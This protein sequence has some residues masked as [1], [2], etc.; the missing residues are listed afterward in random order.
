MFK[1]SCNCFTDRSKTALHLWILSAVL[2]VSCLF[3]YSVLSVPCS[4]VIT[5]WEKLTCVMFSFLVTFP[6]GVPGKVWY[7]V[8]SIPNLRLLPYFNSGCIIIP[9]K[10]SFLFMGHRQMMQT[11][12]RRRTNASSDHDLHHLRKPRLL[13]P[14]RSLRVR[15]E[16]SGLTCSTLGLRRWISTVCLHDL[17]LKLV[18]NCK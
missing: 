12:I 8:V 16:R 4:L 1:P 6:Y 5:C 18:S 3:C 10:P 15:K 17:L 7:L 2:Y 11:Q 14:L 9:F 13:S